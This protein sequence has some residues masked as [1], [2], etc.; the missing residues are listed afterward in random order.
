[1]T[2]VLSA[3]DR[4]FTKGHFLV[5]LQAIDYDISARF[6]AILNRDKTALRN[7]TQF[8]WFPSG[9]QACLLYLGAHA[10]A[11]QLYQNNAKWLREEVNRYIIYN[12]GI[13]FANCG[14]RYGLPGGPTIDP[15]GQR[16]MEQDQE[17]S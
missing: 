5:S 10:I 17:Y 3:Q 6:C 9:G 7:D 2:Q 8:G 15:P 1:M 4:I 16:L 12:Y 14:P 11:T 13:E